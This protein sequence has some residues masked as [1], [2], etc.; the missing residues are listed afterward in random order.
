MKKAVIPIPD[1]DFDTTE[2]AITWKILKT[3]GIE[4]VFSTENGAIGE[5]DPLLLTGVIFGQL[6][7]KKNA[8]D[9]Y[10]EMQKS[11]EF[12]HPIKYNEINPTEYDLLFLPGGH[13]KGMRPY[14]ENKTLQDKIVDFFKLNKQ[15][16]SVCHG[17]LALARSINPE[18]GKSI[19]YNYQLTGLTK[20]LEKL[21]YYLTKWKLG[22]YYRTYPE[23]LQD[24]V[25]S[26]LQQPSN[27]KTGTSSFIP[28]LVEDRNLVSARW[29]NDVEKLANKLVERLNAAV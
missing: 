13:A 5:T 20:S 12:L 8:I 27:F 26:L 15:V 10:H 9:A 21:A 28:F 18:T 29:P 16:G 25:E 1:K 3:N 24:E 11:A 22:D 6:G 23:Y 2:V 4:I 17:T 7:A 14:L 19:V